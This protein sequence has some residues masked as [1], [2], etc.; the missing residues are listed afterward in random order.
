MRIRNH[1]TVYVECGIE[2][3]PP[4]HSSHL[5][6]PIFKVLHVPIVW[7]PPISNKFSICFT[8]KHAVSSFKLNL[9]N[10]VPKNQW[11]NCYHIGA[12]GK[13][14]ANA[15]QN[16]L[17]DFLLK[18][19][20]EILYPK[21]ENGLLPLLKQY[22]EILNVNHSLYIFTSIIGISKKI[23]I[24]YKDHLNYSPDILSIY[25][26]KNLDDNLSKSFLNSLFSNLQSQN[27]EFVFVARSGQI[28][29]SIIK[30]LKAFFNV[31][32]PVN[33]PSFI[34]FSAWEKSAQKVLLELNLI[35]R[36]IS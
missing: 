21:T 25:T 6:F 7:K 16:E 9:L 1:Q 15:I 20:S 31:T 23:V 18:N 27:T 36:D 32:S 8:S 12:V 34:F 13:N 17:P 5:F 26:L 19:S 14:T 24:E 4:K 35:D 28:L 2:G 11:Q 10:E 29:N 30:L 22:N 3:D 33:L